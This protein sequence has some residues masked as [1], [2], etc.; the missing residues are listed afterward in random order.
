MYAGPSGTS[1]REISK[2]TGANIKSWTEKPD[3]KS[4]SS[5]P[6][7]SFVIEVLACP[8]AMLSCDA[9]QQTS[10]MA[11][12]AH[13]PCCMNLLRGGHLRL[14]SYRLQLL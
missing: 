2:Q 1:V 4:L 14:N 7:R 13:S 5:R 11:Y 12:C 6:T 3:H 9:P 8:P 10:C